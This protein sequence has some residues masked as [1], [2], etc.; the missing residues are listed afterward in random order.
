MRLII[1]Q[2][3]NTPHVSSL[4]TELAKV[5]AYEI[6]SH[7][8]A[9]SAMHFGGDLPP[10]WVVVTDQA[11]D[12]TLRATGQQWA[13]PASAPTI[14]I[15]VRF[16]PERRKMYLEAGAVAYLGYTETTLKELRSNVEIATQALNAAMRCNGRQ[17]KFLCLAEAMNVGTWEWDLRTD[18]L[19]W[20]DRQFEIFGINGADHVLKYKSWHEAIHPQDRQRVEAELGRAVT[21]QADY[22]SLFRIY[23]QD[24]GSM[25]Q[26]R[27]IEGIGRL[28][29]DK[30]GAP[31]T[32]YGLNWDVT[33]K[34]RT[35][36]EFETNNSSLTYMAQQSRVLQTYFDNSIDCLFYVV[37]AVDG[38]LVYAAIN[39]SG[40]N[41]VGLQREELIGYSPTEV[42]GPET[43]GFIEGNL[44]LAMQRGTNFHYTPTLEMGGAT[45]MYDAMYIPVTDG[46]GSVIGILGCA[47]DVTAAKR[48][49]AAMVRA[50]KMEAMGF[51]TSSMVH[52]FNNVLQSLSVAVEIYEGENF[53]ALRQ[54]AVKGSHAAL[55]CGKTI[56]SSL[57]AFSREE[58]V[59]VRSASVNSIV[60]AIYAMLR[61][62]AGASIDVRIMADS[63][64][65]PA[66]VSVQY[67][68]LA[69]I[70]LTVN[71]RD[72]M[73][74]GGAITISTSNETIDGCY[75]L[76]KGD[77][78]CLRI[79]DTGAGMSPEVLRRA[80]DAFFTTKSKGKGTGLGL[81]M[82]RS[83]LLSMGGAMHIDSVLGAGTAVCLYFPRANSEGQGLH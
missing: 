54:M 61:M 78:V 7:A 24:G 73:P 2:I 18:G 43:G 79:Q 17:A 5:E 71:A 37:E 12:V 20:S 69:I 67:L 64:L 72:A 42:L 11:T 57:L 63:K 62:T 49:E 46:N 15:D 8:Q 9:S 75:G 51:L 31:V 68:E 25:P 76:V 80:G 26:L 13:V 14:V 6:I 1:K 35:L 23:R 58:S 59:D 41:H 55:N 52:N 81:N 39:Q 83:T 60:A 10:I 16:R 27:W 48:S 3:G 70:N 50:S 40:L 77:Y 38:R 47:R 53:L 44:R 19:L 34:M 56:T 74:T 36:H 28:V 4:M 29:R 22:H 82:V 33:D 32:L 65:W 45:F 30:D 21:G 66:M